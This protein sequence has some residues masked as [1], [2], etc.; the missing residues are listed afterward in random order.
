MR[1]VGTWLHFSLDL[2]RVVDP[3]VC[4]AFKLWWAARRG[5]PSLHPSPEPGKCPPPVTL[6]PETNQRIA[7]IEQLVTK[8]SKEVAEMRETLHEERGEE[9]SPISDELPERGLAGAGI[10]DG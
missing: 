4:F 7:Q 10:P 9:Q 1:T 2:L 8:I 3:E 6:I 5:R